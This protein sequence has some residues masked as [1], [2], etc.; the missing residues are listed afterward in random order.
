MQPKVSLNA[1]EISLLRILE[2]A[3]KVF[4]R[5]QS[6]WMPAS[7]DETYEI[8]RRRPFQTLGAATENAPA[9]RRSRRSTTSP[10]TRKTPPTSP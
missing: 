2:A 8:I 4:G 7:G 6:P 10:K 9:T 1:G 5:V 3:Q